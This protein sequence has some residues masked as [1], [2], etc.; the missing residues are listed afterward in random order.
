MIIVT[1]VGVFFSLKRKRQKKLSYNHEFVLLK[2]KIPFDIIILRILSYLFPRP[3]R[4]NLILN[5]Q[6]LFCFIFP[7]LLFFGGPTVNMYFRPVADRQCHRQ[8]FWWRPSNK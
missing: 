7:F 6:S 3:R 4:Q 1:N 8:L 5:I 2:G